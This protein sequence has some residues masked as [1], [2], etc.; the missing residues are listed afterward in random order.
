[1]QAECTC[2]TMATCALKDSGRI[3]AT[4]LQH[5]D[6]GRMPKASWHGNPCSPVGKVED[7]AQPGHLRVDDVCWTACQHQTETCVTHP[8]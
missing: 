5:E 1:M 4:A 7:D 6:V 2:G 8:L 3:L